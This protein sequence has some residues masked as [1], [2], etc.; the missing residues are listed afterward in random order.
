MHG[1]VPEQLL[2]WQVR[3]DNDSIC[4]CRDW[5]LQSYRCSVVITVGAP[6]RSASDPA[7][8]SALVQAI[9]PELALFVFHPTS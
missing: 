9:V 6:E 3:P 4:G 5:V 8:F 7:E 2:E 1:L